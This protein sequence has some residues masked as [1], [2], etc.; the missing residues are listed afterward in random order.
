MDYTSTTL[1]AAAKSL[2]YTSGF[3]TID[4]CFVSGEDGEAALRNGQAVLVGG[5]LVVFFNC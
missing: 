5:L 1:N 2:E 3:N 4:G